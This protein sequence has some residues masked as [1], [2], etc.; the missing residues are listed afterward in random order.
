VSERGGG[1]TGAG[2]RAGMREGEGETGRWS[3]R[4]SDTAGGGGG[5]RHQALL[6]L[7]R[8]RRRQSHDKQWRGEGE[9]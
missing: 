1:R 4:D 7:Q 2:H 6:P 9:L 5:L 3:R 8:N